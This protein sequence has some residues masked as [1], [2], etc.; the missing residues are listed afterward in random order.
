MFTKSV[1]SSMKMR[2]KGGGVVDPE[3]ELED[4]AHVLKKGGTLYAAVLGMVDVIQG[5][6][7]YYKLQVLRADQGFQY[8]YG[9]H[10]SYPSI[11][12]FFL[13]ACRGQCTL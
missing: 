1:P 9:F 13:F 8:V 2:V 10:L 6:N 12:I 4:V 7:S 5:T 3:S 11:S